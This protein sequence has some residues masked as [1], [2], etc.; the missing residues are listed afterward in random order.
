MKELNL[1]AEPAGSEYGLTTE[2]TPSD[3]FELNYG[4]GLRVIVITSPRGSLQ[5]LWV[6]YFFPQPLGFRFLDESNMP[7]W[8]RNDELCTPHHLYEIFDGGWL[9]EES[10][11]N[12]LTKLAAGNA[13]E[14]LIATRNR[15]VSVIAPQAPMIRELLTR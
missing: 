9:S 4:L 15:C 2:E 3:I 1:R 13:R 14:W 11:D 8:W 5:R 7:R 10:F 6:E 12:S